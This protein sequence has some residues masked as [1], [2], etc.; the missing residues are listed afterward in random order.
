MR[1]NCNLTAARKAKGAATGTMEWD[2][3]LYVAGS[4]R[5]SELALR[6]LERLCEEH[7]AGRYRI[8]IIDL[9]K[10]LP[11]LVRKTRSG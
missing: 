10:A 1:F 9:A 11:A 3:Q 6:N 8:E 4:S 7:L 2:L 5:K